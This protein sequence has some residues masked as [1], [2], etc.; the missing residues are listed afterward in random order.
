MGKGEGL[1]LRLSLRVGFGGGVV[2][3]SENTDFL[4]ILGVLS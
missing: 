1:R 3:A 2:V 4:S